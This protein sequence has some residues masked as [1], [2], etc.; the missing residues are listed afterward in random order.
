MTLHF[1]IFSDV[2]IAFIESRE[3]VAVRAING[4]FGKYD[5]NVDNSEKSFRNS[6]PLK[7]KILTKFVKKVM[8]YMYSLGA[9]NRTFHP[10]FPINKTRLMLKDLI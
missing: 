2:F 1:T 7:N 9:L 10:I 8:K 3:A 5:R 4:T 6:E